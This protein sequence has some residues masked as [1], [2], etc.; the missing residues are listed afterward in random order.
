LSDRYTKAETDA[1]IVALSPPTDITG[2]VSKTG[3]TM[4]GTLKISI[5]ASSP[6]ALDLSDN[7]AES[8][9]WIQWQDDGDLSGGQRFRMGFEHDNERGHG[10]HS[11]IMQTINGN[12]AQIITSDG[13]MYHK[14]GVRMP[15][16]ASDGAYPATAKKG[17]LYYN[18]TDDIIKV[19]NGTEW[20]AIF[21]P[22]F[23]ASGGNTTN[24]YAGFKSHTFTSAGTF[25]ADVDGVVDI[26]LV[27]GGG[28]G[29]TDNAGGGGAGGMIVVNDV[30][31]SAGSYSIVI[32]AGGNA[33]LTSSGSGEMTNGGNTTGLGYTAIGGGYGG[34]GA[35]TALSKGADGGSGGGG[36][37]ESG[38]TYGNGTTGQGFRG[39]SP[40]ADSIGHGGGGGGAGAVG[41]VGNTSSRAGSGGAGLNNDFKT[42]SNICYAGGG[43]GGNNNSVCTYGA[44]ASCGGGYE[45]NGRNGQANTGGGGVGD[46]HV[47]GSGTGGTGGTGIVV[48]RYPN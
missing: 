16:A 22:P 47:C 38:T 24:S 25:V 31:V 46:T 19:Y 29:G 10:A 13:E 27:A 1:K 44:T 11:F 18:T 37:A 9:R 36:A 4:T 34:S 7:G 33:A 17:S 12:D 6:V 40:S 20:V 15:Q 14:E 8:Q 3:D 45:S 39:G 26:L 35:G 23:T 2:K 48:I 28:G 5:G 41:E 43:A 30:S 32:G 42:G 21:E